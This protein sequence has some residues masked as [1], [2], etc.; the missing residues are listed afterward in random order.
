MGVALNGVTAAMWFGKC[1]SNNYYACVL[2]AMHVVQA[3]MM[4]Q[5]AKG[6]GKTQAATMYGAAGSFGYDQYGDYGADGAGAGA[7]MDG[8]GIPDAQEMRA[9]NAQ[10][11]REEQKLNDLRSKFANLGYTVSADGKSV[12]LPNGKTVPTSAFTS[13]QGLMGLGLTADQIASYE[14]DKAAIAASLKEKAKALTAD[15]GGGGGGGA[16]GGGAFGRRGR[17]AGDENQGFNYGSLFG[18]KKD[19]KTASVKGLSKQLGNDRIGVQADNI[20]EMMTRQ[21]K[22]EEGK[23]SFI[24]PVGAAVPATVGP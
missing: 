18:D 19:R 4:L 7:D 14:Q 12:T 6:A 15:E 23:Q 8:N 9:Y 2:G 13:K 10:L 21:Y 5:G 16:G 17:G 20:F 11:N 22:K 3:G 1:S 24:A